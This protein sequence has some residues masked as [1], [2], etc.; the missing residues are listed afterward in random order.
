MVWIVL[1]IV[2]F[3]GMVLS[4]ITAAAIAVG[5]GEK[6]SL[7][8][9]VAL[10]NVTGL[11]QST[12]STSPLVPGGSM[13]SVLED[14]RKA[15]ED[16]NV[17]AIVLWLDSPGGSPAAAEAVYSRILE[18][19]QK[20]PV[21][22]AMGDVAA[23][24]AYYIASAATKIVACPSTETGSIG[25]IFSTVNIKPLMDR[26]GVRDQTITTGPYKD[27]GS[28]LREM[29]PDER[30]LVQALLE[31][32]YNQFVVNVAKG[33]NMPIQ[34]VRKLADGRVFT[35]QQAKAV[36]LV[37]ELGSRDYAIRLA[38]KLGGIEGWPK[39]KRYER[40]PGLLPLLFGTLSPRPQPWYVEVMERPGPWLTIPVPGAGFVLFAGK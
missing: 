40:A 10:I 31:D 29:R 20:K 18:I 9:C 30:K 13:M 5:A 19:R 38:A 3:I 23:S 24:G 7:K 14:L 25:V 6:L 15:E 39:I 2:C 11:I 21:V 26:F 1:A 35:G 27:T 12:G 22:A 28:P 17:K 36:G 8:P 4:W 33:R 37:D 16:E 32:I 34:A